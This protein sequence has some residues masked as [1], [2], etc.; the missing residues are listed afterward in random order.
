MPIVMH[1]RRKR[2][3]SV[4][5]LGQRAQKWLVGRQIGRQPSRDLPHQNTDRIQCGID[6][7]AYVGRQ[8]K[9]ILAHR[10]EEI[11]NQ[12]RYLFDRRLSGRASPT[13]Q[14]MRLAKEL[15]EQRLSA[16]VGGRALE[17]QQQLADRLP[18]LGL[19]LLKGRQNLGFDFVVCQHSSS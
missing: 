12:M 9:P 13:L 4:A 16:W 18:M 8:H 1:Q 17:L 15:I 14:A 5:Y 6:R 11:L 7:V 3:M 2:R 19:L 10:A